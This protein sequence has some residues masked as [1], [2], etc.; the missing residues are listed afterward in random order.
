[1]FLYGQKETLY[2]FK[3]CLFSTSS[4]DKKKHCTFLKVVYLVVYMVLYSSLLQFPRKKN[5][6]E[7]KNVVRIANKPTFFMVAS[8]FAKHK[9]KLQRLRCASLHWWQSP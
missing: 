6:R 5:I 3:G 9:T 4:P 1:M 7:K 8:S 2:F